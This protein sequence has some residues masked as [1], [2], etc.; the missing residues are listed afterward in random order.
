MHNVSI[1]YYALHNISIV[2]Y[3]KVQCNLYCTRFSTLLQYSN[4]TVIVSKGEHI[5]HKV[6]IYRLYRSTVHS[7]VYSN[8]CQKYSI[9]HFVVDS[10]L[11]CRQNSTSSTTVSSCHASCCEGRQVTPGA[12]RSSVKI[13]CLKLDGLEIPVRRLSVCILRVPS[14][15]CII[16]KNPNAMLLL[17]FF[18][19]EASQSQCEDLS[20]LTYTFVFYLG[21]KLSLPAYYAC[22]LCE[23]TPE[24]W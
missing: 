1:M 3:G 16:Y 22:L 14:G 2:S 19:R 20:C 13:L 18:L 9:I 11:H 23:Y 17:S 8:T 6:C 12:S 21:G 10:V 4:C 5:H 15:C 7:A 24:I